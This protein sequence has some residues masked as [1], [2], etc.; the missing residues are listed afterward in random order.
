MMKAQR[1]CSLE[2]AREVGYFA[3][4]GLESFD[5]VD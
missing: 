2:A 1:M 3:R 4:S 5:G